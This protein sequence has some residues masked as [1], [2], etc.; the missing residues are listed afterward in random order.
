MVAQD[1][2][3]E[4]KQLQP[5]LLQCR[6]TIHRHPET[7]F[8]LQETKAL[9]KRQLTKMGYTPENAAWWPWPAAKR[10]AGRS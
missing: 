5:E 6:R 10:K 4:A 7:G 9:V 3:Q 1:L 8:D 2:L